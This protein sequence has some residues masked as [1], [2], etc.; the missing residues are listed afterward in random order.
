MTDTFFKLCA[1]DTVCKVKIDFWKKEIAK[2]T[3]PTDSGWCRTM[4]KGIESD[5]DDVQLYKGKTWKQLSE[6][7]LTFPAKESWSPIK[8]WIQRNCRDSKKCTDGIGDW[9]ST[10][11]S[12]DNKVG[13]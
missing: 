10:I 12:I 5:V 11:K 6:S 13:R 3:Y 4:V 1:D 2:W 8:T 7:S 9:E